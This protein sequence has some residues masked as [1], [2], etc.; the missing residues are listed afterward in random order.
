MTSTRRSLSPRH[1][2]AHSAVFV[3]LLVLP[4]LLAACGSGEES[5]SSGDGLPS[6]DHVHALRAASDGT[7]LLGLHGALWRS[8]DTGVS[9]E[10]AGM[11][12][13]DA[14]A[15][16]V[17]VTGAPLLVGGHDLLMRSDDGGASFTPLRPAELPSLDIH[18]LAQAPSDPQVAYAFVVGAGVFASADAGTSWEPRA[19]VGADIPPDVAALAVDPR[20]PDVVLLGSGS[21]GIFR[22][23]DGARSFA[24]ATDWGVLG[25]AIGGT[26]Q[27]PLAV[28]AT[29]QGID[30]STDG[31]NSWQNVA[32][33]DRFE[34]Q[35]LAV[36]AAD[37]GTVWVVTEQPRVLLRSDDAGR[38]W[39]EVARA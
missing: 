8:N 10:P 32:P 19:A 3:A 26:A 24:P 37:D 35:P 9:W 18:A 34:G 12:G 36:T 7:L 38:T 4:L 28:A 25:L 2:P 6:T 23:D 16:G 29:Y 31:G 13:Q 30:V 11:E 20:D 14:M 1:G 27:D 17:A 39:L 21:Q 22:S 33:A 15:I 5:G